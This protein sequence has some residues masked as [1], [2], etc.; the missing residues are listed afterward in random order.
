MDK[1]IRD[2]LSKLSGDKIN[3]VIKELE[4]MNDEEV[5]ELVSFLKSIL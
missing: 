1:Q 5:N 2:I 4:A 3:K